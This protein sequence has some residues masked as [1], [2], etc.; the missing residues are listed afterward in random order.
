M[1][2]RILIPLGMT[3]SNTS[4]RELTGPDVA[5][6][7]KLVN[8]QPVAIKYRNVDNIA[9]AGAINSNVLEM[10][11]Y[12]RFHLRDGRYRGRQLLSKRSHDEMVSPQMITGRG[13]DPFLPMTHFYTYG[14]GLI[15]RDYYGKTLV[16]HSGGIDGMLSSMAWIPE[17]G[18]GV[19]VLTNTDNQELRTALT[20]RIVDQLL[21]A[22]PRDWSTDYLNRT[23]AGQRSQ[24]SIQAAVLAQRVIGTR[25]SLG[26]D[27]YVGSYEHP[28]FGSLQIELE[29]NALVIRRSA[30]FSGAME[31]WHNDM[32]AVKWTTS[33][34]PG[35]TFA[36]FKLDERARVVS[37]DVRGPPFGQGA[38]FIRA[39]R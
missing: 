13:L 24:D 6:P 39:P 32:F 20:Y 7:H 30:E 22:P 33:R 29:D 10:A 23:R 9:G 28:L 36:L 37:L 14:L 2:N 35:Y 27:R 25:P 38:T 18:A 3:A 8:G 26:L 16:S 1:K 19:I 4:V 11:E 12:L 5:T 17:I 15:I 31:H 21:G 34:A